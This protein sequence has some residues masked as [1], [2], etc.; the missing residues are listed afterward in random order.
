MPLLYALAFYAVYETD[1]VDIDLS[2]S[3]KTTIK[4]VS[5]IYIVLWSTLQC[6][7]VF[8]SIPAIRSI[9]FIKSHFINIIF[10]R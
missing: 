7:T 4:K 6:S 8:E 9:T 2:E 3:D 1:M 5:S 10:E